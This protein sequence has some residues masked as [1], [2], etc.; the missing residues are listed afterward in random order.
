MRL[1]PHIQNNQHKLTSPQ[2]TKRAKDKNM[3]KTTE[4]KILLRRLAAFAIVA[5]GFVGFKMAQGD[6]VSAK[7]EAAPTATPAPMIASKPAAI[8]IPA[9][10]AAVNPDRT[11]PT[12]E[13]KVKAREIARTIAREEMIRVAEDVNALKAME[14]RAKHGTGLTIE[15]V[16]SSYADSEYPDNAD[17]RTW[18]CNY[19]PP[20]VKRIMMTTRSIVEKHGASGVRH[21]FM[22]L[23]DHPEDLK[24]WAF[25]AHHGS[26][27]SL[28]DPLANEEAFDY[29]RYTWVL[30]YARGR[31]EEYKNVSQTKWLADVKSS[32]ADD[33]AEAYPKNKI[34]RDEF[35]K[36]LFNAVHATLKERGLIKE[37]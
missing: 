33:A 5:V 10:T 20:V 21:Y 1:I 34:K 18:F 9:A 15:E 27:K 3:K 8:V 23:K 17:L 2:W 14:R 36:K 7:Q 6:P 22:I 16:A 12:E 28:K 25:E 30:S 19:V 11:K 29:R 37:S 35:A 26:A 31:D 32:C 4:P 24:A 13:D